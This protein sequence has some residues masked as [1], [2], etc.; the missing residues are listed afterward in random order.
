[1]VFVTKKP[2]KARFTLQNRYNE[3]YAE[4]SECPLTRTMPP[5][6]CCTH[7][8]RTTLWYLAKFPES[9]KNT[10]GCAQ[11]E[12]FGLTER[13]NHQ[14]WSLAHPTQSLAGIV[15]WSDTQTVITIAAGTTRGQLY[16]KP[17][18]AGI[19]NMVSYTIVPP[20][21]ISPDQATPGT[22]VTIRGTGF[23]TIQAVGFVGVGQYQR[24]SGELERHTNRHA[25]N[26]VGICGIDYSPCLLAL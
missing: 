9:S 12:Q 1:M 16:V 24:Q 10:N 17:N 7:L 22:Q 23:G 3:C 14:D 8:A 5:P 26:A 13:G 11:W 19:S 6:L 2:A 25:A 4:K 20:V 21:S 18:A 15:A